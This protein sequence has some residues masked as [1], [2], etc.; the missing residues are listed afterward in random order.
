MECQPPWPGGRTGG[1]SVAPSRAE[2]CR[3]KPRTVARRRAGLHGSVEV[4]AVAHCRVD[5]SEIGPLWLAVS[6]CRAKARRER[7]WVGDR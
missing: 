2:R 5:A 7:S 1:T 4:V 3:K 6:R